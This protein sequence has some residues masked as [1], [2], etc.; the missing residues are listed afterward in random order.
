MYQ[1]DE[2]ISNVDDRDEVFLLRAAELVV[3]GGLSSLSLRSLADAAGVSP[4][5]VTYRYGARDKLVQRM[6]EAA[7]ARDAAFWDRSRQSV[8]RLDLSPGDLP[9]AMSA[10]CLSAVSV[11]SRDLVLRWACASEA[12]RTPDLLEVSRGWSAQDVEFWRTLLRQAGVTPTLAPALSAC[13]EWVIR[14]GL[15]ARDNDLLTRIWMSDLVSRL[16]ARLFGKADVAADDSA[17]R[18]QIKALAVAQTSGPAMDGARTQTPKRIIEAAA[19]LAA[20]NGPGGLTHRAIAKEAGVSL[21]SMTHHFSS[22]GEIQQLAFARLYEDARKS[23]VPDLPARMEINEFTS[24][25]LPVLFQ[26]ANVQG[27][28][29]IAMDEIILAASRTIQTEAVGSG[30]MALVGQTSTVMLKAMAGDVKVDRIDGQIFRFVMTGLNELSA[31]QPDSER[32]PWFADNCALFLRHY[33][34]VES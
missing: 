28:G 7:R 19:R 10:L 4:S 11:A 1:M 6:F 30:L 20:Q 29:A 17:A 31:S 24:G 27:H 23:S 18:L 3:A 15:T 26:R 9:A 22:L 12:M 16:A 5:L 14:V 13:M 2:T 33:L 25:I 21:S 34:S 8:A 32:T